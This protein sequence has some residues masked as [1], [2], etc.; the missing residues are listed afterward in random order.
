MNEDLAKAAATAATAQVELAAVPAENNPVLEKAASTAAAAHAALTRAASSAG[1]EAAVDLEKSVS[2]VREAHSA[3][4][5]AVFA[6]G[7]AAPAELTRAA[8]SM[9]ATRIIVEGAFEKALAAE[10]ADAAT[11]AA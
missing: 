11:A 9:A 1:R 2:A 5:E 8:S 7:S 10:K 6:Q 3:L 4:H